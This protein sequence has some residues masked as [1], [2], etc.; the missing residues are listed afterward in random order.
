[1]LPF[2]LI[3]GVIPLSS[4]PNWESVSG[5]YST[6]GAFA[7]VNS[8]G[9]VDLLVG[10]GNDMAPQ[11]NHVYLNQDGILS[12]S[13]SWNSYD[14]QYSGHIAV[15]DLNK[16]GL[17]DLVVANYSGYSVG[18]PPQLSTVYINEGGSLNPS[19]S[20][21]PA[22]SF[23]SFSCALGDYDLD[24]DLDLAFA[25]GESYSNQ[26]DHIRIYKNISNEYPDSIFTSEPV[27]MSQDL[28][29]AYDI[30]FHDLNRDG[31]LDLIV[32]I[33]GAPNLVFYNNSGNFN[34]TPDWTSDDSW[35]TI[36]I[37]IG[38][39]NN[40]GYPDLATADNAQQG[41]ISKARLY[42]NIGG[43]LETL[44]SWISSEQR[45]YFSTVAFA[46]LN[47]DGFLDLAAGGWWEPVAV[48]ENLSGTISNYA[49]WQY[50]TPNSNDLVCEK[51]TF[52]DVDSAGYT[53]SADTFYLAQTS[54]KFGTF[55]LRHIPFIDIVS[56]L[57]QDSVTGDWIPLDY[58]GFSYQPEEGWVVIAEGNFVPTGYI[59][60]YYWSW[61]LDLLVTNW[62]P[63]SGNFLFLN[64]AT[65]IEEHEG[66]T[67]TSN[68]RL[69]PNPATGLINIETDMMSVK[70][71]GI[72]DIAG[73]RTK[74][75][76]V[77]LSPGKWIL[78]INAPMGFY[79]V[80]ITLNNNKVIQKPLILLK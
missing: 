3:I 21:T 34:T 31:W 26:P 10:N 41:G 2:I 52:A 40:D 44:P 15:G 53:F 68:V 4:Q 39:V 51:I 8:D 38:D 56:V 27:W 5:Y 32:G 71:V 64:T 74:F 49:D 6:G 18:W 23:R 75:S 24:G 36:Q 58:S 76:R 79:I 9:L 65:G 30:T 78:R 28:Y 7:D 20:W 11:P 35:G 29:Y 60:K 22:D 73:R 63:Q 1:M 33:D 47:N 43:T 50:L 55:Y 19:P 14:S 16:D 37:A 57:Y 70:E 80:V 77:F 45:T 62:A 25:L 59:L 66:P 61:S 17:P 54:H 67:T 46:D 13:P 12:S 72:F 69:F 42:L 48:Y